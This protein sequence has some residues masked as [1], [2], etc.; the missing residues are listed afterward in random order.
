GGA[1]AGIRER[2]ALWSGRGALAGLRLAGRGGSTLPGRVALAVDPAL[3]RKLAARVRTGSVLVTGT[4]GKTTTA[5]ILAG[6]FVRCGYRLAYNRAGAN[7]LA[8][9]AAALVEAVGWSGRLPDLVVAEVDEATVPAAAADLRPRV[10]V[11]TNFFRDQL[12]RYG[13]LDRAVAAVG[14]GLRHLQPAGAAVLN[15]DDPRVAALGSGLPRRILYY[16]VEW[17]GLLGRRPEGPDVPLC[18]TCAVPFRYEGAVYAHLGHYACPRCGAARPR[19]AVALVGVEPAEGGSPN[20]DAL[21]GANRPPAG[22]GTC[23]LVATP[24]G[25]VRAALPLPGLYNLYNALA[26]V[27]GAVAL[28][29]PPA[30]IAGG[31]GETTGAFGR[32]ERL[33]ADGRT[34]VVGLAK[35]PVGM[36]EV[37]RAVLAERRLEEGLLVA[38]ND[39]TADGTD[40]SWLWDVDCEQLAAARLPFVV[41]SGTRAEDMAVRLKYAGVDPAAILV[42]RDIGAAF[43]V[44][45][46]RTPSGRTLFVVPTYTAL[47]EFRRLMA[48]RRYAPAFWKV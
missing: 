29:L 35:N 9:V 26:A 7:L 30:D 40:V 28:G 17:R 12:D 24:A 8:G 47:L 37:L 46:G 36:S 16:G 27:A 4:N 31:L 3:V 21:P 14:E 25:L 15:A 33:R 1:G 20:E 13:E 38:I 11:V 19:P 45:V 41:A 5:R 39:R 48:K 18:P 6:V 42:E 43:D 22:A 34:V 2:V 10:L 23:L 32:M 44:A